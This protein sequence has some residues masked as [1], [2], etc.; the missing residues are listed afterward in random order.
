MTLNMKTLV[1]GATFLFGGLYAH[2]QELPKPSPGAKV[3]QRIGL[4]D[5]TVTYSRPSV[6][7]R[8]IWGDLVPFDKVWRVGANASTLVETTT[9]LTI[10]GKTLKAGTYSLFM[11][12]GKETW[13]VMFNS[14]IDGWGAGKYDKANDVLTFAVTP[15]KAGPF[16]TMTLG[17]ENIKASSGELVMSWEKCRVAV[18]ITVDVHTQAMKN[19]DKALAADDA[20]FRTYRNAANY[21]SDLGEEL[22]RA[23]TWIDKSLEM[24]KSWYT[25]WIKAELCEA[26]GDKKTAITCVEEAITLG[27]AAAKEDGDDFSYK[28]ELEEYITK[29]KS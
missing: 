21:L 13:Q 18:A 12:P 5:I 19:I 7:E 1:A 29:L 28:G 25:Y 9:D 27:V 16:E 11:T 3:E 10:D 22:D 23:M 24:E 26:T 15:T 6:K 14:V 8:T 17:F 20:T 2:A 4:T